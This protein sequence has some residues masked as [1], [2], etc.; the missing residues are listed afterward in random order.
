MSYAV[1]KNEGPGTMPNKHVVD[2]V[3]FLIVAP[4]YASLLGEMTRIIEH[5][6]T[7]PM[8]YGGHLSCLNAMLDVGVQNRTAFENLVRL[9]EEKR[10]IHPQIKR[11]VY[12]RDL[13]RERRARMAKALELHE[14]RHGRLRGESRAATMS[15]IQERWGKAKRQF[16]AERG[17]MGWHERIDATRE[18]WEQLDHQL[19]LNLR[20]EPRLAVVA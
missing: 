6:D 13:M 1:V 19:D 14:R 18:F 12:Q 5:W 9:I 2:A 15:S 20:S 3:N 16:L 17:P 7:H 11:T 8:Y 10:S 4:N